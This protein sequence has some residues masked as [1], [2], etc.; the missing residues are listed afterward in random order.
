MGPTAIRRM[1]TAALALDGKKL[2][3]FSAARG[4][5]LH[6]FS[7]RNEETETRASVSN[8]ATNA[9]D[10]A[11]EYSCNPVLLSIKSP[12]QAAFV[13]RGSRRRRRR[14]FAKA[15]CRAGACNDTRRIYRR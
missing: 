12:I 7:L 13:S 15:R 14:N 5:F 1:V 9:Q 2:A 8:A 10:R 3:A 6:D 11:P 4:R